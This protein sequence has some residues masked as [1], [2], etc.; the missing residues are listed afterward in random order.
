MKERTFIRVLRQYQAHAK[1]LKKDYG[2]TV[3]ELAEVQRQ[4][5]E[6]SDL[7]P[8]QKQAAFERLERIVLTEYPNALRTL[9]YPNKEARVKGKKTAKDI[10]RFL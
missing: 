1:R 8:E 4:Q 2:T 10:E 3:D 6:K 9:P 7:T 5:I